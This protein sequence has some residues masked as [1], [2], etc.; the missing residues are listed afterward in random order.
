MRHA[1]ILAGGSGTRLWPM[2]RAALPKQLLPL[3]RG[4]SLLSLAYARVEGL[5]E[6]ECRW[7]CAGEIHRAAVL[8]ALPTLSPE[9][10]LGEPSGRDTLN[11]LAYA[12]AVIARVDPHAT[13]AV[14]TADQLIEPDREFRRVLAIGFDQAE[15]GST[16]VTFGIKPTYAATGFGYLRLGASLRGTARIVSEFKEKPDA[17]T[18]SRWVAEGPDRFL[19]NGGMFVW[20]ASCFLD[21]IRRYE[22]PTFEATM[23]IAQAW[24]S[25][26]FAA[27]IG[28][29]YPTL[30]KISVDFA[31]MEPASHDTAVTVAA[32]PLD[33]FWKDIGSWPALAETL[34]KDAAGNSISAARGVLLDTQGCLVASSDPEHVVA[35]LGCEDLVVVHTPT[36]TLVC[37]KDRAEDLKKLQGMVVERY[38][39]RYS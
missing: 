36:A 9:R 13:I 16:L 2:S 5:V 11:A 35:V 34:E 6:P 15:A 7:V 19:W 18:A 20:S 27:T 1:L 26:A 37:R 38:G 3:I 22:L 25:E 31:V 39:A 30:K 33:L 17:Q 24:G 23:R 29:I 28:A 14:L 4:A 10:Y 12:T 32:V 21:C 8:A